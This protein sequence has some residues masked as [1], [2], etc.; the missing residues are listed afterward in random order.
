MNKK[1]FISMLMILALLVITGCHD[2]PTDQTSKDSLDFLPISQDEIS[3]IK[4]WGTENGVWHD[5]RELSKEESTSIIEWIN[6]AKSLGSIEEPEI[7]APQA[8]IIIYLLNGKTIQI[9]IWHD[10]IINYAD[11]ETFKIEQPDLK[12]YLSERNIY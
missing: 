9:F 12:N 6:G 5:G 3:E 4:L 7:T 1:G 11:S 10:L 8:E 2:K